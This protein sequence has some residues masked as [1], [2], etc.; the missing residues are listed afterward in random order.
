MRLTRSVVSTGCVLGLGLLVLAAMAVSATG[1][2]DGDLCPELESLRPFIG[3]WV[4]VREEE[5]DLPWVYRTWTPV[6]AGHAIRVTRSV[7][8]FDFE[9]ESI[10]FF[11]RTSGVLAYVEITNNDYVT[12]GSIALDGEVFIQSGEQVQPDSTIRWV[13][14]TFEFVGEDTVLDHFSSLEDGR[15]Q[16]GH[17]IIYTPYQGDRQ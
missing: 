14:T 2:D 16:A 9:A 17:S 13:R 7:P 8:M 1:A 10:F 12:R 15:W 3:S 4:G 11:D 6:L 5:P